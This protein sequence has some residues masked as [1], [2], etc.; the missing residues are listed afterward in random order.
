MSTAR[1]DFTAEE[2]ARLIEGDKASW[3]RFVAR[4]AS[5]IYA[6][7]RRRLVTAGA[8]ADADDVVQDVFV[9]LCSRDFHLLRNYDSRR[10]RLTTWLTVVA[11]SVS[12]DHLRRR[13]AAS[14]TLDDVP[15]SALAVDPKLPESIKIPPDLL[16]GRQALVLEML[17]QRE[18]EV[19]EVAAA[20]EVD[21]QTVRST[22][23]KALT[24]LRAHFREAEGEK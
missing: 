17:Y 9:R 19:S 15:E 24:K 2:L 16:S 21:P 20:L 14:T 6:A 13:R 12:I 11:T 18:M 7:V 3:D 10:A 22:H 5:V 8:S 4:Y 1:Q 23:H